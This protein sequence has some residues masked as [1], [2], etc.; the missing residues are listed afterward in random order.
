[1]AA[2]TE[3]HTGGTPAIE[4]VQPTARHAGLYAFA[5]AIA[6][7][8]LGSA[9]GDLASLRFQLPD[10]WTSVAPLTFG[11]VRPAHL[12]TMI[13]GWASLSMLGTALWLVPRLV[14]VPLRWPLLAL[15]GLLVWN[16]GLFI[17]VVGIL[18][19][20]TDGLEW[21]EMH[22]YSADPLL[23]I[24]GGLVG[25]SVLRT[26]LETNVR[27]L[28]VS[29]W[30]IAS[31]FVWFPIIF[32]TGNWPHLRGAESVAANWFFAHNALGFWLTAISLGGVYYFIPKIL[33][34]P[35]YSYQLSL[36]GFWAFAFFYALNGMHH[37]IGGPIPSWMIAT[38]VVAS[39][40]MVI[41]VAAVAVNHHLSMVGRFGAL[42]YSPT[43]RFVVV[44]AIAYTAVSLQ[45]VFTAVVKVNRVTHFTHWTIAHSHV[46]AYAFVTLVMFG[47]AYYI[48]PRLVEREWPSPRLIAWHFW[49]V[50]SGIAL[51]VIPLAI[52]GVRQGLALDNP[53]LPFRI[54]VDVVRPYLLVRTISGAII[55]AGHLVFAWH[56]VR[57]VSGEPVKVAE[58]AGYIRPLR[59]EM[60]PAQKVAAE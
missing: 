14:H 52:G 44:G 26:V 37:V 34:R 42:R 29:I 50:L 19:G 13:Y 8:L 17:G 5:T 51:Y 57:L 46:G 35:I 21:L 23:V 49:L 58:R 54:S 33:G 22:R 9:L 18:F 4:H 7:L 28:Y 47:C 45:G 53:D 3:T 12:N 60:L 15:L 25:I 6:W 30:Y 59:V 40:M 55:T 20:L 27:H 36:L 11:R 31:A 56:F 2:A 1:M 48:V 38:S 32:I 39:L 10:L 16:F 41:P 24:G 43:L